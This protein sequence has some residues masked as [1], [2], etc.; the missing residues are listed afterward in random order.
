MKKVLDLMAAACLVFGV[1]W[2]RD[3][4]DDEFVMACREQEARRP[5]IRVLEREREAAAS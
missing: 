1:D 2:D 5:L 4:E 3:F